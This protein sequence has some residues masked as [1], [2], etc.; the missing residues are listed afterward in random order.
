[1]C[2]NDTLKS[3]I[4]SAGERLPADVSSMRQKPEVESHCSASVRSRVLFARTLLEAARLDLALPPD[5]VT[6]PFSM[7]RSQCERPALPELTCCFWFFCALVLPNDHGRPSCRTTNLANPP[8]GVGPMLVWRSRASPGGLLCVC[9]LVFLC[10]LSRF[11]ERSA[12]GQAVRRGDES[13]RRS[14]F[15]FEEI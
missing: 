2:L 13:R 10:L 12:A 11:T 8:E 7:T 1:M 9:V 6:L 14:P 3:K 4:A 5:S 15:W